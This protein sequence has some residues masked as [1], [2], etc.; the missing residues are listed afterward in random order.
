MLR[1]S[2]GPTSNFLGIPQ[3]ILRGGGTILYTG[4]LDKRY[5]IKNLLD[6]FSDIEEKN[7]ELWI[8]GEGNYKNSV[9]EASTRDNRIIYYGQLKHQ[10]VMTLQRKATLLINPR[11][12]DGEFTK[13]SFPSKIIEYMASGRP[14]I[15]HRL[16]G[17]PEEY[18]DH[19]FSPINSTNQA[20]LECINSVLLLDSNY[21]TTKGR[22]AQEFMNQKTP[23]IQVSKLLHLISSDN[24][25]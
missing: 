22:H 25:S 7:L 20:L 2:Q 6:T 3:S 1:N 12:P 18:Y 5:G 10:A 19:C 11:L 13:F 24:N 4:T 17:I 21:L 14:V 9:I 23:L 8:C 15:M 16:P